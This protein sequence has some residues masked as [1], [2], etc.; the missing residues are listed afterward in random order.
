MDKDKS[1]YTC[2]NL[3]TGLLENHHVTLLKPFIVDEGV[4]PTKVAISDTRDHQIITKI[5]AHTTIKS[6]TRLSAIKF[7]VL[8]EGEKK[9]QWVPYHS[10][11][12]SKV[13][14]DYLREHKLDKLIKDRFRDDVPAVVTE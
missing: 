9:H 12:N 3:V 11:I 10:L 13:L 8:F 1:L 5:S 2:R 14:H 4:D 6:N 7:K